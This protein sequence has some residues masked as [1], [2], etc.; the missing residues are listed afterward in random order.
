MISCSK[1]TEQ[2]NL[3]GE[4]VGFVE[5]VDINGKECIDIDSVKVSIDESDYTCFSNE[6][7]RFLIEGINPGTYNITLKRD[8]FGQK[9]IYNVPIIGGNEPYFIKNTNTIYE[10]PKS[11]AQ[12]V[13]VNVENDLINVEILLDKSIQGSFTA[14]WSDSPE[15]SSIN[16]IYRSH[17]YSYINTDNNKIYFTMDP[18][19]FPDS[20][21]EAE[22]IYFII[23][24]KN[25]YERF[26]N[27]NPLLE[28]I[29]YDSEV[30]IMNP[31]K[32]E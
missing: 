23:T 20:L 27:Y 13:S 29:V 22:N 15:L 5:L 12:F 2:P 28:L 4:L 19:M 30:T 14:Y 24:V 17:I 9:K 21:L 7:G 11:K 6:D 32:V 1:E 18:G 10:Q 8:N 16:Y 31:M 3:K 25:S 26:N